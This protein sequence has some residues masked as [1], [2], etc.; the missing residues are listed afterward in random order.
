MTPNFEFKLYKKFLGKD[1]NF[2]CSVNKGDIINI[3]SEYT[4]IK[5]DFKKDIYSL[6]M[7]FYGIDHKIFRDD[8]DESFTH[9]ATLTFLFKE[10]SFP[11]VLEFDPL[12]N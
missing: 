6:P 8:D 4:E 12:D 10:E 2:I 11:N 9:L 3:R 1:E 7:V 5:T